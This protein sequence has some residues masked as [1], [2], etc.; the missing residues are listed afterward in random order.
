MA[1]GVDS[2]SP[3]DSIYGPK[4]QNLAAY[5]RGY[6]TGTN[7]VF[8]GRYFGG[9]NANFTV[10]NL[11]TSTEIQAECDDMKAQGIRWIV[12]I[13]SPQGTN[14]VAGTSTDGIA[15]AQAFCKGI[16]AAIGASGGR[17]ALPGSGE[18]YCYLDVE[19]GAPFSQDYWN[20]WS[21]TVYTY[22]YNNTYPFYPACYCNPADGRPCVNFAN[23]PVPISAVWANEPNAG[24]GGCSSSPTWAPNTCSGVYTALWQYD[25]ANVCQDAKCRGSSFPPVD[26]DKTNP[27]TDGSDPA[28]NYMLYLP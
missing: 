20:G 22:L 7:P 3:A 14:R 25:I 12:P 18:L 2:V 11:E 4:N 6:Y 21:N 16:G 5:V 1:S 10:M 24:C 9:Y 19:P 17:M 23:G 15:D 8:W 26:L 28:T 13:N 27:G